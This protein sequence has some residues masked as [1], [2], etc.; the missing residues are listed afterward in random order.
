MRLGALLTCS[1][2]VLLGACG[3]GG[4]K[5]VA[6]ITEACASEGENRAQCACLADSLATILDEEGLAAMATYVESYAAADGDQAKGMVAMSAFG[7]SVLLGALQE[8]ERLAPLCQRL[9]SAGGTASD[10]AG[11]S[12]GGGPSLSGTYVPQLGDVPA[13]ERR[14]AAA[15]ADRRWEFSDDGTVTTYS[16]GGARRWTW[17][18]RG[19]E[20]R[21]TGAGPETRGE[22]RLFT[23]H[24]DGRCI[25]DGRG[26]SS[27]DMRFCPQS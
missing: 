7:D 3:G 20:I 18:V 11:K 15:A 22:R 25:W 17:E 5:H 10:G 16:Q 4:S 6:R 1:A 21:L 27:V 8:T 23:F 26:N 9:V 12:K 13:S 24:S 2:V 14:L 19:K